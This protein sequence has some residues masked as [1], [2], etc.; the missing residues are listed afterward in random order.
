ML[1]WL[2]KIKPL[3]DNWDN[4][5]YW[6]IDTISLY[7]IAYI[8]SC[9]ILFLFFKNDIKIKNMGKIWGVA[10]LLFGVFSLP[11]Y[12]YVRNKKTNIH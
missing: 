10:M 2:F 7:L 8:I 3:Y 9:M 5:D 12:F 1:G 11:F 4:P 6:V